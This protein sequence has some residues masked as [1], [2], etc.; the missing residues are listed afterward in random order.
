MDYLRNIEIELGKLNDF[1]TECGLS[2]EQKAKVFIKIHYIKKLV[3]SQ[4]IKDCSDRVSGLSEL[5]SF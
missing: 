5:I 4:T 1:L 2:K 3:R